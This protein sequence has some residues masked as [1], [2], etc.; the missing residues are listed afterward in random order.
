MDP[1][2]RCSAWCIRPGLSKEK[3]YP[4]ILTRPIN[5]PAEHR[6]CE[7][8]KLYWR[9]RSICSGPRGRRRGRDSV[10][11]S[12]AP[13]VLTAR[14]GARPRA[15]HHASPRCA[16]PA[17]GITGRHG[18]GEWPGPAIR[19]WK[20][21]S[22]LPADNA[23]GPEPWPPGKQAISRRGPGIVPSHVTPVPGLARIPARVPRR[24]DGR[25]R[26]LSSRPAFH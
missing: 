22:P 8:G 19:A 16:D 12:T 17:G 14:T 1:P 7:R 9:A 13:P 25:R 23:P 3:R 24:R 21:A 18:R 26:P 15:P 6:H 2:R 4:R 20:P 10:I 11:L 5:P